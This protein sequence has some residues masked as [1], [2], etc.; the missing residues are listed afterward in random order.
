MLIN[1]I[2]RHKQA[3][4]I[5]AMLKFQTWPYTILSAPEPPM[6]TIQPTWD[7]Y[8]YSPSAPLYVTLNASAGGVAWIE[9]QLARV[10]K[11]VLDTDWPYERSLELYEE[12]TG[13][14]GQLGRDLMS[15]AGF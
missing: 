2:K 11:L 8:P 7:M 12:E 13:G 1:L 9:E 4:I 6:S 14:R 10:A 15:P 5:G 3:E